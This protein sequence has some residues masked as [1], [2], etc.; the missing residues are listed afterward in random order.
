MLLKVH[1]AAVLGIDAQMIDVEVDLT[2]ADRRY[3]HVVGLPDTAIKESG[4]RVLA[5]IRNCG[6]RFPGKGSITVNLAPAD[7]KK[8]GS[9]YDLPIAMALLGIIGEL[10]PKRLHEWIIMGELSLDG[11]VRPIRGAL[12]VALSAGKN[13]FSRLLLPTGNTRESAVVKGIDIFAASSLEQV[14][15]LINGGVDETCPIKVDHEELFAQSTA[16]YPDLADVKGQH[17]VKRALEVACAGGH[18]VLL[19]GPPGAGKTM[20]AKRIPSII[21]P[22]TFSEALET[23]AVHSV[24]GLLPSSRPFVSRRPFRA[25]HHTISPAGLV[26]GSSIPRPGEVSVAH[27]GV[28]FLD[29]LPEFQRHALEVL[30]QPLEDGSITISRAVRTL[31]FPAKF[32]MVAAMNPCP[33]G[34]LNSEAKECICSPL[35]IH[36][37]LAKI[38]G[39]L[40]DRIDLH[41]DVPEVKYRE[42]TQSPNGESSQAVAQRVAQARA[43][44]L[45]RYNDQGF[46]CNAQMGPKELRKHCKLGKE[47]KKYLEN[48]IEKLGLS[49]RAYDRILKVARTAADLAGLERVRSDHVAEAIQYRTLDRNYWDGC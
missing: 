11:K 28:L 6:F 36:R 15:H 21:P 41:V 20:L 44:Q 23:S 4:R 42:L 48:A 49:A 45:E 9:C 24:C 13:G 17:A 7:F 3:Y 12:P 39:P 31:T 22:M 33:C 27:N 16:G 30:R 10:D 34:Y 18:N 40:L 37:Y 38:S 26:G 19:I 46:Y 29:E 8:E 5:A 25:P 32:M 14:L 47:G 1:S 43:R 35:Q 2:V